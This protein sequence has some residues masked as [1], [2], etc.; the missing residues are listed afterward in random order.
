MVLTAAH[1]VFE[2][3]LRTPTVHIGR[4]F[5]AAAETGYDVR[6]AV[7]AA[8]HPQYVQATSANDIALLLLDSS[9]TKTALQLPS[10]DLSLAPGTPVV[11]VGFGTTSEGSAVLSA[12]LQHVTVSTISDSE[13]K[14][15]YGSNQILG[16][17]FCAGTMAGGKDSCQGDSGG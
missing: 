8:L 14:A 15:T 10:F 13:C 7:A 3:G 11:A 2:A 12:T 5:T 17:M 9:S 1:C 4:S 16:G 6:K